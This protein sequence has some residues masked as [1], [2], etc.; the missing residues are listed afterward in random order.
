MEPDGKGGVTV[1]G[2]HP[3]RDKIE[4]IF[5]ENPDLAAKF[6]ALEQKFNDLR[7]AENK[8]QS[9]QPLLGP[10]FGLSIINDDFQVAFK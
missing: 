6:R 4:K 10:S 2:Q 9:D 8:P 5:E 1:V 3:D 7:T